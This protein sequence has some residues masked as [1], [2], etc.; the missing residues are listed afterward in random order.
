[1]AARFSIEPKQLEATLKK[2]VFKDCR[3]DEE[4]LALLM[5]SNEY[6]LNP[7]TKQIY[8]FPAKGGGI[9]PVVSV[10]G[11]VHLMNSH[12]QFDGVEFKEHFADGS[13]LVSITAQIWRKDRSRSVTVTEYL[14]ECVRS[15][16]PWK[17]SPCRMLRHKALIQCARVAFGFS[18]IHDEDD[19]RVI[20]GN[21]PVVDIP[22]A[23]V[24]V[25]AEVEPAPVQGLK[26]K[27]KPMFATQAQTLGARL[28]EA[29]VS[30]EQ[31][32]GT[33][34]WGGGLGVRDGVGID[35]QDRDVLIAIGNV[36]SEVIADI[37]AWEGQRND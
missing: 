14:S 21:G 32:A 31:V 1:M 35:E 5:V 12:P 6:G 11:W 28:T 16:D 9:V 13:K 29:G 33:Y 17:Q 8:A 19:A 27:G 25:V 3:N 7:L 36:L 22:Q 20:S 18:G 2:T 34:A 15:T 4:F 26:T 24:P 23:E 10:D 37:P 30:W